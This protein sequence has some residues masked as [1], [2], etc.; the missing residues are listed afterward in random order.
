MLDKN[1]IIFRLRSSLNYDVSWDTLHKTNKIVS[2]P[3]LVNIVKKKT[4]CIM[5][6]RRLAK[7]F[8][9]RG[10]SRVANHEQ[11]NIQGRVANHEQENIQGS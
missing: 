2:H 4:I 9:F 6:F 11:E 10:L 7:H 3:M 5:C 8:N 1:L